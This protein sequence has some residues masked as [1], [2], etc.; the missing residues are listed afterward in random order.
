MCGFGG[1]AI[2]DVNGDDE[3]IATVLMMTSLIDQYDE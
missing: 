1:A 3:V 2:N